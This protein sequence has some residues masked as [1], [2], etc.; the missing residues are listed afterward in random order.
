MQRGRETLVRDRDLSAFADSV[1]ADEY[2]NALGALQPGNSK[3]S[4]A[5]QIRAHLAS[6]PHDDTALKGSEGSVTQSC[7]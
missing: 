7:R 2:A 5:R 1:V 3:D 4:V 6:V